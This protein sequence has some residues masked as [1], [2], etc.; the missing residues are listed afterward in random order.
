MRI[1]LMVLRL[2]FKAPYYM[3]RIWWCGKKKNYNLVESYA[4]VKKVTINANR[5]GRVKI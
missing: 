2:I 4:V 1:A 3:F 5:A